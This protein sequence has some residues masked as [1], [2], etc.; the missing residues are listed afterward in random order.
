MRLRLPCVL[1]GA[2]LLAS[3]QPSQYRILV[4]AQNGGVV[5]TVSDD[6]RDSALGAAADRLTVRGADAVLWE[7]QVDHSCSMQNPGRPFPVVYGQAPEC[8]RTLVAP[9][10]L[11]NGRIYLASASGPRDGYGYFIPGPTVQNYE[12]SEIADRVSGWRDLS[13]G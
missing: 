11:E 6:E 3:C 12:R 2:L 4:V 9:Q 8:Y 1:T 5:L 13:G 7:V 10:P